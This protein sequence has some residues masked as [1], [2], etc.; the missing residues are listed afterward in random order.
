MIQSLHSF[1]A[2]ISRDRINAHLMSN[3]SIECF[4]VSDGYISQTPAVIFEFM[5][6]IKLQ[7]KVSPT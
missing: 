7:M 3:L 5:D 4:T 1:P 6:L 2:I